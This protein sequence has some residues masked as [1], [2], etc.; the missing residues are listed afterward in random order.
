MIKNILFKILEKSFGF[1][2]RLGINKEIPGALKVYNFLFKHSWPYGDVIEVQGSKMYVG[3]K[4]ESYAIK[5]TLEGY[6]SSRIHEKATTEI[7]K[8]AV[9]EGDIVV[10]AGA[11]IGYFTL[12][13]A[14]L[15]GPTGKVFAF[16]PEPKNYSYLIKNI[17]LNHYDNV[18]A[19][20]KAVSDKNGQTELYIC[21]YDTGHHTINQY[22]GVEVYS[23]G[24]RTEKHS[25][26]IE[27]VTL[28]SF[29]EGKTDH[30][31]AIKMD[32]EG[33]EFLA[34]AGMDRIL[35]TNKDLK[36]FIEFFPLLIENMG[37]S[38][39]EFIRKLLQDY[40]FSI[41]VIPGEHDA[42]RGEL[43]K[44]KRAEDAMSFRRKKEDHIN[45]FL[46]HDQNDKNSS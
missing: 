21:D 13:A 5:K 9:K 18:I 7:F 27:T 14:R 4:G 30:I 35:R 20:Q 39:K 37:S 34:L 8:E 19:I 17:K 1:F 42:L 31:D 26:G 32:V 46:K 29:L 41:Y 23:R 10:D 24:R 25:I 6:A 44:I 2:G 36:I 22:N 40:N 16:E 45:L 43:K 12:L 15:V 11:N 3:I 28:D 33:A 38:P